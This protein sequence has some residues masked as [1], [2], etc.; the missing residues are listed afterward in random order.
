MGILTLE[1]RIALARFKPKI[2]AITG[3]VGKTSAKDAIAAVLAIKFSTR[4]SEKSF[5]SEIGA[6]LTILGLPNG[7]NN[8]MAWLVIM[9]SGALGLFRKKYPNWLVLEIGADRPGDIKKLADW[10]KPD[11]VVITRFAKVP[12]HVEFFAS[13][14]QVIEEKMNLVRA[15]KEDGVLILNGDDDD[16]LEAKDEVRRRT[17]LYGFSSTTL[18]RALNEKIIYDAETPVGMTFE[19]NVSIYPIQN[20]EK[21]SLSV[22]ITNVLGRQTIY[23][24]LAAL[25]VAH[26]QNID[27]SKAAK[28]MENLTMPPGRM[29][30]LKGIKNSLIIDDSYNSSPV[31]LEKA[32][33]TLKNLEKIGRKIAVLGDMLELGKYSADEHI[34][35]GALAGDFVDLLVTVGKH[36]EGFAMGAETAG[37]APEK[38]IR[39]ENSHEAGKYLDSTITANDIILIKGSQGIRMERAVEEIMAE[40]ENKEKLLVRQD[41]EWQKR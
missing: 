22:K 21:T 17:I 15:L 6:P 11:V 28:M 16:I 41:E 30:I 23:A 29:K 1:A 24:A 10:L 19:I 31:A 18:V 14:R 2:V 26:S 27:L 12:V 25:A 8:P 13:P 36:A 4:K 7:W 9:V 37:L 20:S 38:I 35:A 3:S 34:K 5:N 33:L 32:L 40:P 39:F